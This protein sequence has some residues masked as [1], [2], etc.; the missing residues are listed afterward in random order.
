MPTILPII[1]DCNQNCLFCSAQ[2]R[3]TNLTQDKIRQIVNKEKDLI[4]IS[5]GEPL[6]SRRLFRILEYVKKRNLKI[7]LETNATLLTYNLA[8]KLLNRG[9]DLFNI[10]FP[11]H[12]ERL[13]GEITQS[14]KSFFPKIEAIKILER[15]KAR[16]RLT[17]IVNSL[18]YLH[19]E[20]MVEFVKE[21]FASIS[22]IQFSFI[23]ILGNA[24]KF[25]WINPRYEDVELPLLKAFIKCRQLKIDFLV[26]HIPLCFLPG[27]ESHHADF[28]KLKEGIGSKYS[29][30]EK[31]KLKACS[32]CKLEGYCYGVRK[33]YIELFGEG[34]ILVKPRR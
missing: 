26:D 27:F 5:G 33:D 4:V 19:M 3:K 25:A 6:L 12:T 10:N 9:V 18:N 16:I 11:S 13:T 28:R 20:E 32:A 7:E 23:K 8:K 29:L 21:N 22:Y 31:V 17:H 14:K 1:D 30:K 2:G 24:L 15:L 34:N